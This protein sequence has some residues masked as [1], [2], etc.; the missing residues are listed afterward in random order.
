MAKNVLFTC[1]SCKGA[2]EIQVTKQSEFLCLAP[3]LWIALK[4]FN[5]N[6]DVPNHQSVF[7]NKEIQLRS[8]EQG[9]VYTP[10]LELLKQ[11]LLPWQTAIAQDGCA[12]T[13]RPTYAIV[14][15]L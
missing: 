15:W 3:V 7:I 10:Y 11:Y 9:T 13:R 6:D 8:V 5:A 2:Q 4:R 14:T 12:W 1:D